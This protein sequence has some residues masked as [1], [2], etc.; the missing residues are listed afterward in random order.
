MHAQEPAQ[1]FSPEA[2]G[3]GKYGQVPVNYFNGLPEITIP[4]T[5]FKAKGYELPIY[6]SYHASGNKTDSHP[7]WVGLGWT[8]HAGGVINRIVKGYKDEKSEAEFYYLSGVE[9]SGEFA[10]YYRAEQMQASSNW[11]DESKASF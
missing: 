10:Y 7:G 9:F 11:S 3:L 8:L 4:L 6:L 1:V 2:A 5:T